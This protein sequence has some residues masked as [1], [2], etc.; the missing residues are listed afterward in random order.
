MAF[1]EAKRA[2]VERE[3]KILAGDF[4]NVFGISHPLPL[5]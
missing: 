5:S 3:C 1:S 2:K 4:D